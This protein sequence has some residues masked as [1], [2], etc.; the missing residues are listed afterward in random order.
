GVRIVTLNYSKWD[1]HGHPYGSTFDR[2]KEGSEALDR[3]ITA[4]VDDLHERGL[5]KDVTVIAWGEFGRT[6]VISKQV[7][8]DHWPR[9]AC[10][11]MAGGG[12][13]TGQVI[14]ATDRLGGEAIERPVKFQD[15]FATLY[16]NLGLDITNQPLPDLHGRPQY[17][18]DSAAAPLR[19]LI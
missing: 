5:D 4:L 17:I 6:P 12:M 9:V 8:R 7:G 1:W 3:S 14:G 10:A 16:R 11:L 19:E 2:C 13:R 15:V 18:L